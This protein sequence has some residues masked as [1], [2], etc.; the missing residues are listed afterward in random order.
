MAEIAAAALM[1]HT[2]QETTGTFRNSAAY[3]QSWLSALRNDKRLIVTASGVASKAFEYITT[4]T[5]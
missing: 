2:K 5:V 1:N 4:G 3:I